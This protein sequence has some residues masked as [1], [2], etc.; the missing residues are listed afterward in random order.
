MAQVRAI[1]E[2]GAKVISTGLV[3]SSEKAAAA[4]KHF[5]REQVDLVVLLPG[6]YAT[7][8]LMLPAILSHDA[9]VLIANVQSK[10]SLDYANVT[11][12]GFIS[13][14]GVACLSE[15]AGV[16]TRVRRQ[17][18][19]VSGTSDDPVVSAELGGHQRAAA[20][21]RQMRQLRIGCIGQIYPGMLD[22]YVDKTRLQ[23]QLGVISEEIEPDMLVAFLDKVSDAQRVIDRAQSEFVVDGSVRG[24][25]LRHAARVTLAF[26][27]LV[28]ERGLGALT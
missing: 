17:F 13:H 3:D 21:R 11:T 6:T 10:A 4:G 1:L 26:E 12:E 8:S 15:M 22:F 20:I 9:P 7:S 24:E 18:D 19:V 5:A 23:S 2:R 14:S 27:H 28:E 25:G 16:L